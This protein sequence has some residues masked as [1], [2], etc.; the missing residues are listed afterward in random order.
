MDHTR[1]TFRI[2]TRVRMI[3]TYVGRPRLGSANQ[4]DL[5]LPDS[6]ESLSSRKLL[7]LHKVKQLIQAEIVC[8]GR[9]GTMKNKHKLLLFSFVIQ[10]LYWTKKIG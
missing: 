10:T 4:N 5:Y 8:V 2:D 3:Q 6:S 7:H 1:Q 9:C